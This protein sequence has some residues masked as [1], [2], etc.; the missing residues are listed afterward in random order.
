VL[1]LNI[2]CQ[3][4]DTWQG[5][6]WFGY[7]VAFDSYQEVIQQYSADAMLSTIGGNTFR[8]YYDSRQNL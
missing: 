8:E 3:F 2:G 5:R 6:Y 4:P 1:W 7:F